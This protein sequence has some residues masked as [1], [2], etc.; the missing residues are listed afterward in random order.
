M[1]G[2]A[3]VSGLREKEGDG[4]ERESR[5]REGGR[6]QRL[7]ETGRSE[8]HRLFSFLSP[9]RRF[10]RIVTVQIRFFLRRRLM[11]V[12]SQQCFMLDEKLLVEDANC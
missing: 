10:D 3:M 5:E 7:W 2:E 1:C 6:G 4:E 12:N 8:R 11:G 9:H